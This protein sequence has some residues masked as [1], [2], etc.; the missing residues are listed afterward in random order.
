MVIPM[1]CFGSCHYELSLFFISRL[2]DLFQP[3]L[4]VNLLGETGPAVMSAS[5]VYFL[6]VKGKVSS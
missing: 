6:D 1:A 3:V 2:I 4:T 5:A